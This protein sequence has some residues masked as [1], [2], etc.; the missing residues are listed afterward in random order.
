MDTTT[1]TLTIVI[2]VVAF[3]ALA[4]LTQFA[5]RR[6]AAYPLRMIAA[7]EAIPLLIG[8][9]IESARPFHVSFGS[10]GIGGLRTALALASAEMVVQTARRAAI[11]PTAPLITGSDASF[12]PLAGGALLRGYAARGR[13]DRVS[14]TS[15]R[16]IP[17]LN[18]SSG[19]LAFAAALTGMIGVERVSGSILVGTYGAEI[20]LVLDAATRGGR[21]VVAGSDNLVGQAVAYGMATTPLIGEE[22]FVAGAYLGDDAGTLAGAVATDTLRWL[23]VGGMI[24]AISFVIA[25]RLAG[26]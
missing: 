23:L 25:S 20:A 7:Y 17:A 16:W 12:L 4:V 21:A 1:R 19:S 18:G 5:R 24:A 26:G 8:E 22:M 15:L 13:A 14:P 11:S 2:L 6:R 9:S 3:V 10:A